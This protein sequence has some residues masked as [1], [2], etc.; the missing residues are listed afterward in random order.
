M[1]LIISDNMVLAENMSEMLC[2]EGTTEI[3]LRND[4]RCYDPCMGKDVD[5]IIYHHSSDPTGEY[6]EW[7]L[8]ANNIENVPV[9]FLTLRTWE[10]VNENHFHLELPFEFSALESTVSQCMALRE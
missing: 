5:L 1:I 7:F 8:I 3:Q 10:N 9:I 4:C 2:L 6:F